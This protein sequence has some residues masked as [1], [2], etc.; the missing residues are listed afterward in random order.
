MCG[1][2]VVG[3][4]YANFQT[5]GLEDIRRGYAA[6]E[7]IFSATKSQVTVVPAIISPLCPQILQN[8]QAVILA[9]NKTLAPTHRAQH[10]NHQVRFPNAR[11]NA[12]R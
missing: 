12:G 3:F 1:M 11:R 9:P 7:M 6:C 10:A 8:T 5:S 4:K 2:L